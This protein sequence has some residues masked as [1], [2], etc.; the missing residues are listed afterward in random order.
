M[1]GQFLL[2]NVKPQDFF[3]LPIAERV[4][5]TVDRWERIASQVER[6]ETIDPPLSGWEVYMPLNAQKI[7][8][9]IEVLREA[10]L[11]DY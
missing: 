5:I 4:R 9:K 11:R 10:N 7:R 3:S 2:D 8:G 6:G 1:N